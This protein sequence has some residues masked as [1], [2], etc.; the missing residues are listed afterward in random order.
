MEHEE[1][2]HW[3]LVEDGKGQV[4]YV[5]VEYLMIIIDETLEEE[6]SD[7][8]GKRKTKRVLM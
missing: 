8:P 3:L 6:E 1:N 4:G 2:K 5:P 7:K